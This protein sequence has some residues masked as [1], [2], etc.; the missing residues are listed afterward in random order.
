MN[1]LLEYNQ[2]LNKV[3]QGSN[4]KFCAE[5]QAVYDAMTTK[6]ATVIASAQNKM[7]D[8]LVTSGAWAKFDRFS[9]FGNTIN[10]SYEAQLDWID[11]SKR[12]DLAFASGG[13]VPTFIPS[14]GFQ[15]SSLNKSYINPHV[16]PANL[17]K[18][19]TTSACFG[20]YRNTLGSVTGVQGIQNAGIGSLTFNARQSNNTAYRI[21]DE[22]T[23]GWT[24]NYNGNGLYVVN[25]NG[26][27]REL[28]FEGIKVK[29]ETVAATSRAISD[30]IMLARNLGSVGVPNLS[31]HLDETVYCYFLGS[32]ISESDAININN[33]IEEYINCLNLEKFD[34][35]LNNSVT[36]EVKDGY[37]VRNGFG[38]LKFNYSGDYLRLKANPT[39]PLNVY[40]Y[41]DGAFHQYVNFPTWRYRTVLLPPGQKIV[42]LVEAGITLFTPNIIGTFI[43]SI[44]ADSSYSRIPEGA[45]TDKII[46]LGD[47]IANSSSTMNSIA[48]ILPMRFRYSDNKNVASL[49]YNASRLAYF[50]GAKLSNTVSNIVALFANVTTTKKLVIELGTNDWS[51]A[52]DAVAFTANYIS[53]VEAV[54]AADP[55]I[56]IYCLS[57]IYRTDENAI[58]DAFRSA[59]A[60]ICADRNT[61]CTHI[62]GKTICSYPSDYI[63]GVHPNDA[64]TLKL[65]NAIYA[66]AYP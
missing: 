26:S 52:T 17:T 58:M 35:T 1:L 14:I 10:T 37:N 44:L 63:D 32:H 66:V 55:S 18:Y 65:R 22:T 61:Y 6:P 56:T 49:G 19:Q 45:V 3:R 54:H 36:L 2:R 57:P 24:N 27:T 40:V 15:G 9:L 16:I 41:V 34:S 5:Y 25:R 38:E 8:S 64:G 4:T 59:I 33:A 43:T 62:A 42:T 48:N 20:Y 30:F 46:F 51:G 60:T 28:Y 53:L 39:N 21:N 7:V 50:V 11:T 23:A 13:S 31:Y 47:S 12:V 29:T